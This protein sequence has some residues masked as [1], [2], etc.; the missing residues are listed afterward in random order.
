MQEKVDANQGRADSH[1]QE[2]KEETKTGM[3]VKQEGKRKQSR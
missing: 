1:L 2:M 3:K